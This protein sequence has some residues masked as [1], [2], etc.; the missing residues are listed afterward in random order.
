MSAGTENIP[1]SGSEP[2]DFQ[3]SMTTKWIEIHKKTKSTTETGSDLVHCDANQ[4]EEYS[5]QEGV[6][7]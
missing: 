2:I 5:A 7:S 6:F 3:Q 1:I 4:P